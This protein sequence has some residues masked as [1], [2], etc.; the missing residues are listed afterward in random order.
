[1]DT[2]KRIILIVARLLI[3][4]VF[5]FSGYVKVIDPWGFAYK[6]QDYFQAMCPFMEQFSSLAIVAGIVLPAVELLI[7][8]NLI[9]GVRL[10]ETTWLLSAFMLVMTGL[11]LWIALFNPVHDCGCFGEALIIS[12]WATFWKNI[13][14][15]ALIVVIFIFMK[16]H[17]PFFKNGMQ[18]I[19]TVYSFAFACCL[20]W[21]CLVHLPSIDFRPYK[22][23]T[24]LVES[25]QTPPD[26][27]RDSVETIL[28]Y[29]NLKTGVDESFNFAE[30]NY[31][32]ST[33]SLWKFVDQKSTVIKKG[34]EP[35]IHDFTIMLDDSEITDIVTESPNYTFVAISPDVTNI[36]VKHAVDLEKVYNFA[37]QNQYNFYLLT[38]SGS[39]DLDKYKSDNKV[40]YPVAMVDKTTLKTIIRSNPGLMLIKD[41]VVLNKWAAADI[42]DFKE[43]LEGSSFGVIQKPNKTE[44]IL[45]TVLFFL[46][47]MGIIILLDKVLIGKRRD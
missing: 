41:S 47:P 28:I 16:Y 11:T 24:N 35:P 8:I 39:S 32:S 37:K 42:P 17:K 13:V 3:G 18:W 27:P 10:K 23:E 38:A 33:D 30:G 5:V 29:K 19:L 20:S 12:N 14:I 26:A 7:G 6:I 45:L 46:L 31:P 2:L 34:Y 44:R 40:D 15:D 4:V 43:K 36:G 25:M 21:Y 9:L 1:M 22:I